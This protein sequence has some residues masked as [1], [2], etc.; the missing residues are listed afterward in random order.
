MFLYEGPQIAL[1]IMLVVLKQKKLAVELL[2][3]SNVII[4]EKYYCELKRIEEMLAEEFEKDVNEDEKNRI[5]K[6]QGFKKPLQKQL[7]SPRYQPLKLDIHYDLE[8]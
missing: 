1:A 5:T 6:I 3:K 8:L 7:Q 4:C 2:G